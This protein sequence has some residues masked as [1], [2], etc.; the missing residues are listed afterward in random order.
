[1]ARPLSNPRRHPPEVVQQALELGD[2]GWT[3]TQVARILAGRGIVVSSSSVHRWL[4]P[5]ALEKDRAATRERER[6]RREEARRLGPHDPYAGM[7]GLA[8]KVAELE[9]RVAALE[10]AAVPLRSVA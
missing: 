5:K 8:R 1:M 6:R 3:S 7:T 10:R 4:N 2:A 9:D